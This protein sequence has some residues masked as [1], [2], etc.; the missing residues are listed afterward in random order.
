MSEFFARTDFNRLEPDNE[1][2][3]RGFCL[4]EPGRQYVVFLPD[5]GDVRLDLTATTTGSFVAEWMAIHTGVSRRS[6]VEG[7]SFTT[8][9][10]NPFGAEPSVLYVHSA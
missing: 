8:R 2:A 5:G 10:D 4:V 7:R 6:P 9:L 3:D 1:F